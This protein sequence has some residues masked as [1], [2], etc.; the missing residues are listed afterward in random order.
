MLT[1]PVTSLA[2]LFGSCVGLGFGCGGGG[3]YII[4]LAKLDGSDF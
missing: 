1:V 3:M 2:E 4:A